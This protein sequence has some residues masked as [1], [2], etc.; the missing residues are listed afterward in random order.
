MALLDHD[1]VIDA[2]ATTGA[3]TITLAGTAPTGYRSVASAYAA[4]PPGTT[5]HYEMDNGGSTWESGIGI[6]TVTLGVATV[7]RGM[8]ESSTGGTISWAGGIKNFRV[9]PIA[10]D[11]MYAANNLSEVNAAIARGNLGAAGL[12]ANTFTAAQLIRLAGSGL[13]P[14]AFTG[15]SVQNTT[16]GLEA[17]LSI[18][19]P[20]NANCQLMLS[21]PSTGESGGARLVNYNSAHATLANILEIW[22]GGA[23]RVRVSSAG[24]TTAAG[25]K[26]VAFA[27]GGVVKMTF[28]CAPPT[29]WARIDVTG[30]R[31]A[32]YAGAADTPEATG[33]SWVVSGLSAS[34]A[35]DDHTLTLAE[36]PAHSHSFDMKSAAGALSLPGPGGGGGSSTVNTTSVGGGAGH[37][38]SL[39]AVVIDS[40][41]AWRPAYEI[42]VKASFN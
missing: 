4:A 32:K 21:D 13:S 42:V 26:Y 35:T 24:L 38:H 10:N 34:G 5:C 12:A 20:S 15:L 36:T 1:R 17:W 9:G 30:E 28:N 2:F 7:T 29:G 25:L 22:A 6:V 41:G 16:A 39:S 23:A 18:I 19:G 31:V 37:A 40:S 3:G 14:S 8:R 33:G 11:Q 27:G